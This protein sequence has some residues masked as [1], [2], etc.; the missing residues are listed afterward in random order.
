MTSTPAGRDRLRE[1]LDAVL[2]E[3]NRSLGEMAR[4]A[5][6]SPFHF[7]RQLR[8]DAGEPPV[9]MRRR[10]ALERAAWQLAGGAAVHEAAEAAGYDS[11]DGFARA[12]AR[13]YGCAPSAY[14]AAG[15]AAPAG[16]TAHWLTAPNGIHFHPPASLWVEGEPAPGGGAVTSLMVTHDLEDTRAL[17]ALAVDLDDE[18]LHAVHQPG[19]AMLDWDGPDDTLAAVLAHLVFTKEVWLASIEGADVP[20]RPD[21]DP[22]ALLDRHDAVAPRW[23]AAIRDIDRRGAWGDRLVDALC[24][25]PESFLLAG[26]VAHVLTYSAA[27]RQRA[28]LLLRAAGVTAAGD[29]DPLQWLI[30]RSDD[31]APGGT[32]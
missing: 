32:Q 19:D 9:A 25:P 4:D 23:L 15:E 8:R 20:A 14:R 26:V 21:G 10:V 18:A 6:A 12:F 7:A 3:H 11:V 1:L 31:P 13:A 24:D 28:R 27:R 22:T 5:H 17:L 16:R 29:G 30:D 2:D